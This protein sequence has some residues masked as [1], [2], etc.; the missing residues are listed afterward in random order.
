MK[1]LIK[2]F[3]IL[4]MVVGFSGCFGAGAEKGALLPIKFG[5]LNLFPEHPYYIKQKT[6]AVNQKAL[7]V[8]DLELKDQFTDIVVD[9]L[10]AKGYAVEVVEDASALKAGEV[11]MLL[12]IVPRQVRQTQ[13][14]FGYGFS[15]RK[16]LLGLISQLPRSYVSMHLSLSRKNSR[17]ILHTRREERFSQLEI[18][19]MPETWD[20]LSKDDKE[21]LEANLR[22]NMAKILYLQ[23]NQFKI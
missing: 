18:N 9:Y 20:E 11:D 21:S 22:S 1:N 2:L 7:V 17:R 3:A 15:D 8:E 6:L 23:L 19:F 12:E 10:L 16:I 4:V 13:G 14:M 5:V